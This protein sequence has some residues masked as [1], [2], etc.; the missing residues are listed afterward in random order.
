LFPTGEVTNSDGKGKDEICS[1]VKLWATRYRLDTRR[2]K[3]QNIFFI[4][5]E[6]FG[7]ITVKYNKKALGKKPRASKLLIFELN[8]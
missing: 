7:Q 6:S 1:I 2:K 8:S 3:S 4:F 5:W